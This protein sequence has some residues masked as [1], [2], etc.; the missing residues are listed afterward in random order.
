M[1]MRRFLCFSVAAGQ[2]FRWKWCKTD[3]FLVPRCAC[4]LLELIPWCVCSSVF[5]RHLCVLA[6]LLKPGMNV[7]LI[8]G[9]RFLHTVDKCNQSN[10][11]KIVVDQFSLGPAGYFLYVIHTS[12]KSVDL[13]RSDG[14]R[15]LFPAFVSC[16]SSVFS[17]VF[18]SLLL[19]LVPLLFPT[20][21]QTSHL[22]SLRRATASY[23]CT[24]SL[25]LWFEV[26]PLSRL[27]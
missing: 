22:R 25:S 19:L 16:T 13:W 2:F 4:R 14:C 11:F 8:L 6:L 9:R 3:G 1:T 26:F 5:V 17:P 12:N 23:I 18:L 21:M 15:N 24:H 10:Q 20:D 7:V 27:I